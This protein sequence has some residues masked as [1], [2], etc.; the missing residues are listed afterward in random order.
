MKSIVFFSRTG[1]LLPLLII[2]NLLFGW[3]FLRPLCWLFLEIVLVLLFMVNSYIL[4]RRIILA[5]SRRG[6]GIDVEAKVLEE[7][8]E[9]K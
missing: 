5:S 7:R 9:S 3:I 8:R 6:D 4:T 1:C 2:F